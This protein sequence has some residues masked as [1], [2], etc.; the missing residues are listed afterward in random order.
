MY[1]EQFVSNERLF[2][3]VNLEVFLNFNKVKKLTDN[4]EDIQ[5]ALS[6]S[7]LIELS[8]D[9][10]KV[11]RKFP[12]KVKDNIDDCTIYV[13][14]IKSESDHEGL[15]SI[16]SEFGNVVY[17]SIPKYKLSKANKGFAFVEFETD[18]EAESAV[19]YFES[20]GCKIPADTNPEDLKSI[21][22]FEGP[23]TEP[24]ED[25]SETVVNENED[26]SK[27]RKLCEDNNL[28]QKKLKKDDNSEEES[29]TDTDENKIKKKLKKEQKKKT[30]Y[31]ELGFQVLSK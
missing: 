6:K 18:S 2:L 20:I 1:I 11:R 14:N 16:F 23:D 31:K 15:T 21:A 13:Q 25:H 9:K 28:P 4:I 27:K 7:D 29:S 26:T 17:V 5:K 19:N 22:T 12:L 30:F 3:D 8:E 10:T 24:K